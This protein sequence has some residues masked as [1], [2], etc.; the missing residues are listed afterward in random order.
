MTVRDEVTSTLSQVPGITKDEVI[1]LH[2]AGVTSLT[3]L[4]QLSY[5]SALEH[6]RLA[7]I[8]G[9]RMLDELWPAAKRAARID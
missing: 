7:G 8:P 4:A 3:E 6:A 2:R 9:H 1:A 5:D